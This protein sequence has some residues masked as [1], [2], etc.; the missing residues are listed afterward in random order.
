MWACTSFVAVI[1]RILTFYVLLFVWGG[2]GDAGA[3]AAGRQETPDSAGHSVFLT[4]VK[5]TIEPVRFQPR[6]NSL[7]FLFRIYMRFTLRCTL[8]PCTQRPL[9][10]SLWTGLAF[11][12]AACT[13][14][15]HTH[16]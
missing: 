4:C 3:S 16:P 12:P 14:C 11:L 6:G 8:T 15:A 13:L 10:L 2:G 9:T 5:P 7:C 1:L